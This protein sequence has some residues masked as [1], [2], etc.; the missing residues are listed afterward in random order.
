MDP[1]YGALMDIIGPY[2]SAILG[3]LEPPLPAEFAKLEPFARDL[4]LSLGKMRG[5]LG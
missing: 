4:L 3:K 1:N 2:L 5:S